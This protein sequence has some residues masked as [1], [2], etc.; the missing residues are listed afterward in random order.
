MPDGRQAA[1]ER[2]AKA[3]EA[4]EERK[5]ARAAQR[6]ARE[7][8]EED[9]QEEAEDLLESITFSVSLE[10]LERYLDIKVVPEDRL[11][12]DRRL[13]QKL[14]EV[15]VNALLKQMEKDP[16]S[17]AM[18]PRLPRF[19]KNGNEMKTTI[20]NLL[21]SFP[22]YF[23]NVQQVILK[24][25]TESFFLNQAPGLDWAIITSE[26]LP[27]S[28]NRNY[29][30]Q[31]QALKQYAHQFQANELRVKRRNLVDA[32]YDLIVTQVVLKETLLKE[33]VDLTESKIGR[34]NLAFIH[35]GENGIMI[36][37]RTRMES[38]PQMGVCPCW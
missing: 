30:Q 2:A 32:L 8:E 24:Y 12:L 28:L 29:A 15:S 14:R 7:Q 37:D 13:Q 34:Q 18:I 36:S 33:T 27:D 35:Y 4:I 38:H 6:Q 25:R 22:Q 9:P 21:R 16:L 11:K 5:K 17:Y 3:R 1:L 10:D 23:E 26:S 20:P 31:R 19:F